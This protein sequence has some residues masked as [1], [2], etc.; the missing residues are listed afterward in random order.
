MYIG[1]KVEL[2]PVSKK[3]KERG[4]QNG[5]VGTVR[6]IRDKVQFSSENG[7]WIL[8]DCAGGRWVHCYRDRNFRIKSLYT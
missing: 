6:D 7:P 1:S 2:S 4:N 8:V 3:G 5:F